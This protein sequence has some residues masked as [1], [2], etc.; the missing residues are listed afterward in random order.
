MFRGHT[1]T[2]IRA[3]P[4]MADRTVRIGSAGKTFS[5]TAWKVRAHLEHAGRCHADYVLVL[6]QVVAQLQAKL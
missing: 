1:H 2:S 5:L 3:L 4:G 6:M